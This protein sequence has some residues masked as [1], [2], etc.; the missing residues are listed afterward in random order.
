M[1]EKIFPSKSKILQTFF[2]IALVLLAILYFAFG[3]RFQY[4]TKEGDELRKLIISDIIVVC[5]WFGICCV[6]LFILFK[7]NFYEITNSEIKHH[8]YNNILIY[9]YDE[10]LY[11]DEVY[12]KKHKTVLFYTNL[13]DARYLI[14]D[15]EEKIYSALEKNCKNLISREEF[16]AKFPNVKL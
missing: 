10:I 9:K 6:I 1:N 8:R 13:G 15:K 4:F 7:Y 3:G 11:I 16:Q 5:A 2:A 12:T 14:L